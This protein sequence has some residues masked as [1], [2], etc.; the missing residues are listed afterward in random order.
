MYVFMYV[1]MYVCMYVSVCHFLHYD[2]FFLLSLICYRMKLYM[3]DLTTLMSQQEVS[4]FN[5]NNSNNNNNNN[6]TTSMYK[7]FKKRAVDEI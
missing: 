7:D 2:L 6:N 4:T 5:K 3:L 1:C